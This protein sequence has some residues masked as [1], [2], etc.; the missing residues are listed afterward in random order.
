M[1]IDTHIASDVY[2]TTDR[3]VQQRRSGNL[4][5]FTAIFFVGQSNAVAEKVPRGRFENEKEEKE[6]KEK[7][8]EKDLF[9]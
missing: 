7:G 4:S 5:L 8:R 2:N 9:L 6:R 3:F 1:F